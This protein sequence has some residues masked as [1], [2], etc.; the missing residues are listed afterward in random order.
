MKNKIKKILKDKK[1]ELIMTGTVLV[2]A[3]IGG[4]IGANTGLRRSHIHV[5]LIGPEGKIEDIV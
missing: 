2:A 5:N 3:C 4:F 1:K